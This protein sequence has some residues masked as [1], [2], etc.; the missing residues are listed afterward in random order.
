MSEVYYF[1]FRSEDGKYPIL[2]DPAVGKK[3]I[4]C[5]MINSQMLILGISY[6]NRDEAEKLKSYIQLKYDAETLNNVIVDRSPIPN[7]DYVPIKKTSR[8]KI[9]TL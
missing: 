8:L 2:K 3:Y 5:K 6:R 7:V 9:K 1:V 4:A